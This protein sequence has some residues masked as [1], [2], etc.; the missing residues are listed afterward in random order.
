MRLKE[1]A[2]KYRREPTELEKEIVYRVHRN[3][4]Q[5]NEDLLAKGTLLVKNIITNK[6][7]EV[8]YHN[9]TVTI[10]Q[11]NNYEGVHDYGEFLALLASSMYSHI[12]KNQHSGYT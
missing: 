11:D 2:N 6:E 5:F 12:E 7:F 1:I 8:H 4:K 9:K 10:F 3:L